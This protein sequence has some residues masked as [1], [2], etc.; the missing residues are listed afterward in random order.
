MSYYE[1]L[2]F[3]RGETGEKNTDEYYRQKSLYTSYDYID[4]DKNIIN[5]VNNVSEPLNDPRVGSSGSFTWNTGAWK[6]T[7]I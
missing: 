5:I 7:G 1:K 6:I 4:S 2:L 3:S